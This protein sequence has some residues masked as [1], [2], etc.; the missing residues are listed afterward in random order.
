MLTYA[1]WLLPNA[2]IEMRRVVELVQGEIYGPMIDETTSKFVTGYSVIHNGVDVEG[3]IA[4][5]L[6]DKD[7]TFG[8]EFEK[9][10][11]DRFILCVSRVEPRK[12][13]LNL[14][15]AV[16]ILCEDD[17]DLQ[18]VMMGIKSSLYVDYMKKQ[19]C[20]RNALYCPPGPRGAVLRMMLRCS[21]YAM[22]SFIETPGLSNLEAAAINKPIVVGDRG[23]VREYFRDLPGVYYCDPKSPSDIAEKIRAA[24]DFGPATELGEFVRKMYSYSQI[25]HKLEMVYKKVIADKTTA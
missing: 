10:L 14:M 9:M 3:E 11:H 7:P 20:G 1:D 6:S 12:N 18:T 8:V 25:A 16:D 17:P 22:P 5:A 21:V 19:K 4:L 2:E 24:L 13:Q 23:S 15:K